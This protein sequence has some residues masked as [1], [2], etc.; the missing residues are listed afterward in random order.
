MVGSGAWGS[1]FAHVLERNGHEVAFVRR[2]DRDWPKNHAPELVF[3]A[4]PCQALRERMQTLPRPECPIVSLIKGIEISTGKRVSQIVNEVW[5]GLSV[6]VL[7]GP[8]LAAEIEKGLPAAAVAAAQ[9]DDLGRL[10]QTAVHQKHFRV[11]RSVDL[12]GVEL[13]GALKNIYAIA[14]G[15]CSGLHAG[16]NGTAGLMT[17]S[18]TEMVRI[19]VHLESQKETLF[20]LS[21][22]GDLMLTA[23]SG[24][25][26]NHMLGELLG[27]GESLQEALAS[28]PGVAEGASTIKAAQEVTHAYK[29]KAPILDQLHAVLYGGKSVSQA[30]HDLLTREVEEE[31]I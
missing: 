29:I 24:L 12:A 8:T 14:G 25:S 30:V 28:L 4:V 22:M 5:S 21:G 15:I 17:R 7:S 16:E 11:Y 26:R 1:A 9:S 23:Y 18:L 13:G 19:A 20:G 31:G 27:K 3:L 2:G 6:G 10:I